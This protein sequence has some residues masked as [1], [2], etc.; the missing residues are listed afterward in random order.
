MKISEHGNNSGAAHIM[1]ES[2]RANINEASVCF[3]NCYE[4]N[5]VNIKGFA[6]NP[7]GKG[8]GTKAMQ[9]ICEVAD[10][11]GIDLVL[12]PSYGNERNR[13]IEFYGRFGFKVINPAEMMRYSK[14]HQTEVEQKENKG[15][16][17]RIGEFFNIRKVD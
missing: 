6:T 3:L 12:K 14:K 15:F 9:F 13:L 5:L 8:F 17:N 10:R 11:E 4:E 1:N 2:C 7:K 16:F